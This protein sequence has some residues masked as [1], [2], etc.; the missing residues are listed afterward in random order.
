MRQLISHQYL[1]FSSCGYFCLLELSKQVN[2]KVVSSNKFDFTK[3]V[4]EY[5]S[6][7]NYSK[8]IKP[9]PLIMECFENEALVIRVD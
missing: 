2:M 8:N 3:T 7:K 4:T 5:S 6:V 1:D 9:S